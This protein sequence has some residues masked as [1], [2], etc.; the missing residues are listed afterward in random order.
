[1]PARP[2]R[3]D[4]PNTIRSTQESS[5][6]EAMLENHPVISLALNALI[7]IPFAAPSPSCCSEAASPSR[8]PGSSTTGSA[9]NF[10]AYQPER[11]CSKR[12][13]SVCIVKNGDTLSGI[14]AKVGVKWQTIASK[15][16]IAS[17]YTIYPG[18][19]LFY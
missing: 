11:R 3:G 14:G 16:G 1:M 19:K 2:I 13:E 10:V 5:P 9:M 15:N 17:P 7:A 8:S 12:S 4:T 6:E 18:Q